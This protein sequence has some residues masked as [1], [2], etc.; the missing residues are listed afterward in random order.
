MA[1]DLFGVVDLSEAVNLSVDLCLA[2][3]EK[4]VDRL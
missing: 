2:K 4:I 1:K 3:K